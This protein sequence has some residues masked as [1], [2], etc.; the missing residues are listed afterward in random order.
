M[1]FDKALFL[2]I[3]EAAIPVV[4]K[5]L[6]V[7]DAYVPV[8]HAGITA[9]ENDPNLAKQ[10]VAKLDAAVQHIAANQPTTDG[11]VPPAISVGQAID[12]VQAVV[13]LANGIEKL[14]R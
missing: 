5:L 10:G 7:P 12:T 9:A 1:T 2:Q 11:G 6:H 4:A 14:G 3:A 8:I 13:T